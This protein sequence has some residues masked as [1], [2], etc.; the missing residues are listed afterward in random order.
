MIWQLLLCLPRHIPLFRTG[1]EIFVRMSSF[2]H[3]QDN[4]STRRCR[5]KTYSHLH[6]AP[7][8]H[9]KGH[10]ASSRRS[11]SK[12]ACSMTVRYCSSSYPYMQIS[13]QIYSQARHTMIIGIYTVMYRLLFSTSMPTGS[14]TCPQFLRRLASGYLSCL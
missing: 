14:H 4:S 11:I 8:F 7:L 5:L 6:S 2:V 13:P 1:H 10:C 3:C 12:T 9:V